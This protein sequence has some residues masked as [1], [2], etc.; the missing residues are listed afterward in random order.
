MRSYPA[1]PE[2]S[3][4]DAIEFVANSSDFTNL[5]HLLCTTCVTALE[6]E[7][8]GMMI[9]DVSGR[10]RVIGSSDEDTHS[11][12]LLEVQ[13]QEGPCY[14]SAV[15]G[16]IILR[17]DLSL[18]IGWELFCAQASAL[19]YRSAIAVPILVHGQ[20]IGALNIFWRNPQE[21]SDQTVGF[22][23]A[24]ADLAAIGLAFQDR[25]ANAQSLALRLEDAAST[26]IMIEQAKGMLAVQAN[27]SMNE[28]FELMRRYHQQTG[29]T[30]NS[31]AADVISRTLRASE[32]SPTSK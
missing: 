15:T 26:R 7:A 22:A 25:V 21:F 10:L 11:L 29:H 5:A 27:V 2:A 23:R 4:S 32:M 9:T 19:E 20:P 16:Q 13:S 12:E 18:V 31:I 30:L 8:S 6:A 28:A 14:E 17:E 24:V 1:H 3:L